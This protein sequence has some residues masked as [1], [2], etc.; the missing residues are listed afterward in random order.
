[1]FKNLKIGLKLAIGFGLVVSLLVVIA[2]RGY[3]RGAD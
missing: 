2:V 1:M 3:L